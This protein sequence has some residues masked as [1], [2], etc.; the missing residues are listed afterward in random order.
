MKGYDASGCLA[1]E[2]TTPDCKTA[3][4]RVQTACAAQPFA[5][6]LRSLCDQAPSCVAQCLAKFDSCSEI[7]CDFCEICDCAG[8]STTFSKCVQDC[9]RQP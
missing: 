3:L 8:P 2:S 7:G 5:G 9:Y 4:G 6:S 1:C